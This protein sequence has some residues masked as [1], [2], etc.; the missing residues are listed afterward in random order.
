[1]M[2]RIPNQHFLDQFRMVELQNLDTKGLPI[3]KVAISFGVFAK[4]AGRVLAERSA[5]QHARPERW[6]DGLQQ[7]RFETNIR[8]D[9]KGIHRPECSVCG[10]QFLG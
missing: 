8:C 7:A 5:L 9:R 10:S 2:R 4:E 6:A 1:M 3:D